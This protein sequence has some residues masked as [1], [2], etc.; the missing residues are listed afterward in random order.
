PNIPYS[1]EMDI[2]RADGKLPKMSS[3]VVELCSMFGTLEETHGL[4]FTP[5]G[6][7]AGGTHAIAFCGS[8]LMELIGDG[9]LLRDIDWVA[10][11]KALPA[12]P[13]GKTCDYVAPD[14]SKHSGPLSLQD[15]EVRILERTT[16]KLVDKKDFEASKVCPGVTAKSLVA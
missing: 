5:E 16:G 9:A 14:G 13:A 6:T 4:S 1:I 15:Q 8:D 12:R 2:G 3:T 7:R 11:V 10:L